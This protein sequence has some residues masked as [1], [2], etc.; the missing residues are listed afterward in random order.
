MTKNNGSNR[1]AGTIRSAFIVCSVSLLH[2]CGGGGGGVN[3]ST[4]EPAGQEASP[5]D[6]A[7]PMITLV[8]EALVQITQGQIYEE[9]G[10]SASDAVD[11]DV[12]VTVSGEVDTDT[13]GTYSRR[14][15]AVDAAG[16]EASKIRRVTVVAPQSSDPV[17][18]IVFADGIAGPTWDLGF[19]AYDQAIDYATCDGD[20]GQGCPSMSWA[21]VS[22]DERGQVLE[23]SRI[24]NGLDAAFF[25]KASAPYDAAEFAGGRIELDI[26]IVSGDPNLSM[27]VDCVYPCTSGSFDLGSAPDSGWQTLQVNV[28][29]LVAQ[30]LNL[31]SV[32]TGLVIWPTAHVATVFRL[33][34]VRWV[35]N[36]NDVSTNTESEPSDTWVNPNFEGPV[37]AMA[38][39]GYSL[40]WSDEFSGDGL[41]TDYW[42]YEL[43]TGSNGWGNNELQ[44]YRQENTAVAEG[45]LII[46]AREQQFGGRQ[47][48]SS[49]LT[50]QTK[51]SFT[52]GR[53]DIRA[54]LPRGQGVW[55]ALWSLGA[56]FD[57]VGWPESGEID[58][59]EMIGGSGREDTVHG[60][61][62][63]Q[64]SAGLKR[65]QSGSH[66]LS[67]NRTL[68]DG[69]HVF[70]L[71]WTPQSLSW[72]IDDIQYH[73][74]TLDES[75]DL[76]AFQHPFFLIFNVAIGGNWPG[77]PNA[78]T[79]FPQRMLVDYVR[80]FQA[81][82]A[83]D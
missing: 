56:R 51:M 77:R 23:I 34:R 74:M 53:V 28:D 58:I 48:T 75:A 19:G 3:A 72:F 7:A 6:T 17:E 18:L 82:N 62:H 50:T 13:I 68:A 20:S 31:A 52:Y 36:P 29:D 10:A 59:M 8:G 9:Q 38:Y 16:N 4:T 71:V 79:Q 33:D 25:I 42:S 44:Y 46:E 64:D 11:G 61:A 21:I 41:N 63:W 39:S 30:D 26:Q 69:F 15:T 40:F 73:T 22:D 57:S 78:N 1:S 24:A 80:V 55:P 32:D 14:Y 47:Y 5:T 2:A 49:R 37:S 43:G 65:D 83:A 66:T 81:E 70:S 45:L 54:A 76:N 12:L 60:T 67:G 35:S 27:K